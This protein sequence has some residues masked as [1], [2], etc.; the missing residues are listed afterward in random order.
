MRE[1]VCARD[2][3]RSKQSRR[4]AK[5]DFQRKKEGERRTPAK[6]GKKKTAEADAEVRRCHCL[7]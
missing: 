4:T 1:K 2:K 5:R 6:A 7:L 3:K